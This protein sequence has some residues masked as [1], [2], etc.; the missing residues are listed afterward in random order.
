MKFLTAIS[1][2]A[3]ILYYVK[4]ET[5]DQTKSVPNHHFTLKTTKCIECMRNENCYDQCS[6][7]CETQ[8][9]NGCL[10]C[11]SELCPQCHE[12][13]AESPACNVSKA[14]KYFFNIVTNSN[15]NKLIVAIDIS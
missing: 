14:I 11:V 3:I 2:L 4:T 1:I 13:C 12:D 7:V 6:D 10:E 5:H 8:N 9:C 15:Y